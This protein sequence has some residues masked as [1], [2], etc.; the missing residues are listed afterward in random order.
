MK[1][2]FFDRDSDELTNYVK[3][4]QFERFASD[5]LR[6]LGYA[7]I[8]LR[9]K[10][11]S[12]EYDIEAAHRVTERRVIG[13]GKAHERSISGSEI[14]A[15]V[16]KVAPLSVGSGVD[17]IFLSVSPVTAEGID[18]LENDATRS[19]LQTVGCNL[20]VLY[21]E[22]LARMACE[23]AKLPTESNLSRRAPAGLAPFETWLIIADSGWFLAQ[24]LGTDVAAGPGYV[25][26]Y[27][28]QG[29]VMRL[30][31][32]QLDRLIRQVP[33]FAELEA[34]YATP[35]DR[36][37]E[38]DGQTEG[39]GRLPAVVVGTGWFDYRLPAPTD[40]FIGRQAALGDLTHFAQALAD[41]KTSLRV[42]QIL[43]RSGVGKSSLLVQ[44]PTHLSDLVWTSAEI[45]GRS[46]RA[47]MQVR[48][49]A[50]QVVEAVN[51]KAST[52]IALP[53]TQ[54]QAYGALRSA[55]GQ[56]PPGSIIL[57]G[58]DQFESV[59]QQPSVFANLLD[60][61]VQTT[62]S[63]LPVL[64]ALARKNDVTVTYDDG[65]SV[66]LSRLNEF[67]HQTML[68]DFA[69]E[70]SARLL[71]ALSTEIGGLRPE[72]RESVLTFS[73][74]FPWLLKRV[75]AH[76]VNVHVQGTTQNELIRT[77]L[78][79]DDL[80]EEDMA[81]LTEQ[82]RAFLRTVAVHLPATSS[83]LARRLEGEMGAG[84]LASKLGD[85]CRDDCCGLAVM[86]TTPITTCSRH[87]S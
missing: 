11:S 5:I 31:P 43:S 87:T 84:H 33:D 25:S 23:I 22:Q 76:I 39:Q 10:H 70:E 63:G 44:L 75:C 71:T 79:A 46:L 47:P 64:W 6:D 81:G 52:S 58:V 74:G 78:R 53:R 77:G 54:E 66:D 45:D 21:G 86:S 29:E 55:V 15:F 73:G 32:D 4:T 57:I 62:E 82:D 61:I 56:A 27:S 65:A 35:G 40:H 38:R 69:P 37:Y 30:A 1:I 19:L 16:G 17:A 24:T 48:Q 8:A 18:Y 80:F 60:L 72:L 13:E 20:R 51:E 49:L 12:L 67:S 68:R 26:F 7:D 59:L 41:R 2:G 9:R 28:D 36:S 50:A 42:A 34:I 83:E 14:A 3:G 85:F